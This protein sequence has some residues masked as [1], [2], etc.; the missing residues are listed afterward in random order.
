MTYSHLLLPAKLSCRN[1]HHGT[2]FTTVWL[3][4]LPASMSSQTA[5]PGTTNKKPKKLKIDFAKDAIG[6]Q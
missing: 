5:W 2:I 4:F 6:L 1:K 3:Q